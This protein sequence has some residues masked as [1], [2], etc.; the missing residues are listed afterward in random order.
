MDTAV[1][2]KVTFFQVIGKIGSLFFLCK[3]RGKIND[4]SHLLKRIGGI[5]VGGKNI[6]HG[7]GTN[8]SFGG[9]E[10]IF[11]QVIDAA[12]TGGFDR[13]MLFFSDRCIEF[14]NKTFKGSYLISVVIRPY[15]Q[16]NGFVGGA[17]SAKKRYSE[18]R[19]QKNGCGLI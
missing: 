11:F 16:R 13:N 18:N 8:P 14:L 10:N 15:G 19:T 12:L 9:I 17:A 4:L 2:G 1:I 5:G 7:K 3:I 6:W